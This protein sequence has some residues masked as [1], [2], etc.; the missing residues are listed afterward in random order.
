MKSSTKRLAAFLVDPKSMIFGVAIFTLIGV[1][2][3]PP[4]FH[5]HQNI[6]LAV[7]L[8]AS[9]ILILL[10][11][12]WSNLVAAVLSGYLP[13]EILRE[14]WVFPSLAEVPIL[15]SE[16]FRLFFGNFQIESQVLMSVAVTSMILAR[17]AFAIIS[18]DQSETGKEGRVQ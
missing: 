12:P 15:S 4:G 3:G 13:V 11:N 17:A 9:S 1:W 5:F 8:L 2:M 10:D 14:F 6:F 7:L 16:H 18:N